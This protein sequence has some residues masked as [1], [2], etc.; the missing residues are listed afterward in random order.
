MVEAALVLLYVRERAQGDTQELVL[1]RAADEGVVTP[2]DCHCDDGSLVP[3][4]NQC[5]RE[6]SHNETD[7]GMIS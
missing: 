5:K 3:C 2:T 6:G 1:V 7:E 4:S